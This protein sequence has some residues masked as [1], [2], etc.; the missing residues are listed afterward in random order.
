M[1]KFKYGLLAVASAPLCVLAQGEGGSGSG[2]DTSIASTFLSDASEAVT[3]FFTSNS[4]T[5]TALMGL[6]I[7]IM[8]ALVVLKLI[9]RITSR[10]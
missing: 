9:K 1:K 2:I 10:A 4:G 8:L 3:N 6:G 7:G 5:F